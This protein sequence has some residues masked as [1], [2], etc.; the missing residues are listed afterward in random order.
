MKVKH[1]PVFLILALSAVHASAEEYRRTM[2]IY[3]ENKSAL[4]NRVQVRDV[5]ARYGLPEDCVIAKKVAALCYGDQKQ[6]RRQLPREKDKMTC[7]VALALM[8][9][10]RCSIKDLIFDDWIDG[11]MNVELT[12]H[13]GVNGLGLVGVRAVNNTDSWTF[14]PGIRDGDT[15]GHQ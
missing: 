11:W 13:T 12:I 9:E 14:K 6:E 1:L 15:V 3:V 7:A 4:P 2:T 8:E 10:P 5:E